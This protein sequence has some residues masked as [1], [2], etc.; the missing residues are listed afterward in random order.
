[1]VPED[2]IETLKSATVGADGIRALFLGGS[3]GAGRADDWSDLD[4]VL[5][6]EDGACDATAAIW[7]TA[8]E[9]VGEIILWWDRT[10]VPVLINAIT[11]D[12]TRIDVLMLTPDQL[13]GQ[14]Q[15]RLIPLF[16]HDDLFAGLA[17]AAAASRPDPKRLRRNVEEFIRILGLLPLSVGRAEYI[18]GV[19]GVFHL[20][21]QLVDLMIAETAVPDRGGM[22]TLNRLLTEEQRAALTAMPAPEATRE[23]MIAGHM[24]YAAEFLPRARRLA[25][26]L[27]VDWPERFEACTW[28][29]LNEMLAL[30]KPYSAD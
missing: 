4:F 2:V 1:M 8:V 25:R 20:R 26:T 24:T 23:A 7:R 14:T 29:R 11:A 3:H 9:Q 22:L 18:N 27:R 13:G 17:A 28:A 10:T 16:D 12:W 5:V 30:E 6:A 15:D 19:L 21:N